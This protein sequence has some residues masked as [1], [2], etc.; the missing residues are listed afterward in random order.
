MN[1]YILSENN[2]TNVDKSDNNH[3]EQRDWTHRRTHCCGVKTDCVHAVKQ[4]C[5]QCHQQ[6]TFLVGQQLWEICSE[7]PVLVHSNYSLCV[8]I[9][10]EITF[11]YFFCAMY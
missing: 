1:A 11:P 3:R 10:S 7:L 5:E 9:M 8:N 2:K 6:P 4:S